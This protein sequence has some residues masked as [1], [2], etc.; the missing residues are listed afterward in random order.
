MIAKWI[1]KSLLGRIWPYVV[2]CLLCVTAWKTYERVQGYQK[3]TKALENT[4]NDLDQEIKR[5]ELRLN[6][7]VTLYQAEVRNLTVTKDNLQ[8]KYNGLLKASKLKAKDV[9]AITEIETVV[10]SVDTVIA[11][12]DS[13]GGISARLS[14]SFVNI[15]VNVL[16]DRNTIIE[17]EIRDSLT[18][19]NVQKRHSWLFGLIKWTEQK[20][21]RVINNNPKATVTSLQTI[22]IYEN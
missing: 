5:S 16:P 10:H 17:Y 9:G 6:D 8:A 21:T 4:I 22:Q 14:D 13:F 18:V 12:V 11:V 19:I 7:S 15:D 20:S 1:L 2:V 3:E